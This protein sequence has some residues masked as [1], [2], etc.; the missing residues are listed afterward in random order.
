[1][2]ILFFFV[3]D[4]EIDECKFTHY[5]FF[6]VFFVF[7]EE[8]VVILQGRDDE[9]VILQEDKYQWFGMYL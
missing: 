3:F 9:H 6:A 5:F 8:R 4:C 1:M 2:V 7:F